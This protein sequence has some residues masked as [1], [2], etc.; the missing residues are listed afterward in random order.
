MVRFK[1]VSRAVYSVIMTLVMCVVSIF[2][3]G[4][5]VKNQQPEKIPEDF[6]PVVRFI[7][8]S[9]VHVTTEENQPEQQRFKKMMKTAYA[10]S[11]A[12][13]YD[14]LDAVAVVGDFTNRGERA[15]YEVFKNMADETIKSDETQL[16]ICTGNHEYYDYRDTDRREGNKV[17]EEFFGSACAH[18]KIGGYHFITVSYDSAVET[19]LS[20][21][22]W[23][24]SELDKA[25]ADTA[26]KP[27]FVFQHTAPKP[28]T[29]YGT[30]T[31]GDPT[32]SAVLAAYPQVV[33]FSGHSHYPIND[34]RSIAQDCFTS[35]QCGTLSYF[36]CEI[37]YDRKP[38]D[39]KEQ[40]AQFYIVEADEKGNV[41]IKP[42]DL[43]TDSFFEN[44]EYYLTDLANKNFPYSYVN[45][46][47][48]DN[49]PVFEENA[50]IGTT[51]DFDGNTVLNFDG[52]KDTYIVES[53]RITVTQGKKTVYADSVFGNYMFLA[54]DENI[55]VN[56]G[57]LES[58][59]EYK[60]KIIA[61]NAYGK[62]SSTKSYSF[63]AQ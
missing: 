24:K 62:L 18:K 49:A 3:T 29:L 10:Y 42:Y 38:L 15:Q 21:L 50:Q 7:A 20:R 2:T 56:L 39:D 6:K 13:S 30:K 5:S 23:L 57:K 58:G 4:G 51:C 12:Q 28:S 61:A 47:S 52:A 9:D 40:A 19:Y 35:L 16:L 53:Y 55:S 34:P 45:R 14:K 22:A 32:F 41:A 8:C 1:A 17:F 11:A 33:D 54:K 59:K 46:A 31:W 48:L 63:T 26:D 25:V 37:D 27:I 43:I 36:E 44:C 60:V